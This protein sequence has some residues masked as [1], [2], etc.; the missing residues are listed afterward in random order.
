MERPPGAASGHRLIRERV[1]DHNGSQPPGGATER[2][3][4]SDDAK[5]VHAR[6]RRGGEQ[7]IEGSEP[8]L[9]R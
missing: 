8:I 5:L 4:I 6:Q 7:V 3:A 9:V 2:S 1:V